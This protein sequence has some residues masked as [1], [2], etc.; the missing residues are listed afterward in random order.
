MDDVLWNLISPWI[1]TIN[2]MYGT[3]VTDNCITD[4]KIAKFFPTLTAEQVYSPLFADGFWDKMQPPTDGQWFIQQLLDEGHKVKIVTATFS[5]NVPV[6]M[7]RFFELYPMLS[8]D[9]ITVTSDK[10]S[11][12]GDILIDDAP[13]NLE[14]GDY[15]KILVSRPHNLYYDTHQNKMIRVS[16]LKEAYKEIRR[17]SL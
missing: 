2:K 1:S 17:F 16:N 10:Q 12:K 3:N 11:V 4:W 5:E 7:R 15:H 6:K 14:R 13:H 8:W 9:D